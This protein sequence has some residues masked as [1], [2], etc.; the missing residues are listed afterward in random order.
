MAQRSVVSGIFLAAL[1]VGGSFY[2]NRWIG[3]EG[4][5]DIAWKGAGVGLLALWA[6]AQARTL[7][8]WLIAA[9]LA[10]G[11]LGDV[12]LET[13]GITIGA[14]AFLAGHLVAVAL[15]L[16]NG[17]RSGWLAVP[18]A[19]GVAFLAWRLPADRDAAGGIA[20]Y[21]LGLGAMAGCALVSRFPLAALGA[22]LF[23]ASDLL[24]FAELGPLAASPL[25]HLLI[26]PTYFAGQALIAWGVVTVLARRRT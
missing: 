2:L 24:I 21:A 1:I 18:I 4:A 26:W 11:A 25:P 12:L 5:A 16:R 3:V 9:V 17:L 19:F 10:L 8:G 6:G 15:Y 7:D 23:V 22:V 13:H 14:L 20:V